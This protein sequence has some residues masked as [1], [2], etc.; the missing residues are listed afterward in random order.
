LRGADPTILLPTGDLLIFV[1]RGMD[2]PVFDSAMADRVP[3]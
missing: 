2:D 3:S 1:E